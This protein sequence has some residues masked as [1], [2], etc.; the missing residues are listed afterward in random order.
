LEET[1]LINSKSVDTPMYPNAKLLPS[2]GPLLDLE[3]YRK[4]VGKLNY[5][6]VTCHDIS[7]TVSVMSQF[8]NS[9]CVYH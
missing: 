4:L 5:L 3:K 8:L 6:T 1:E 9:P 7:F 2:Q